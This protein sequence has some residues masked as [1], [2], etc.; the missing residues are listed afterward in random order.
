M[1]RSVFCVRVCVSGG[2]GGRC[3]CREGAGAEAFS[4]CS[5]NSICLQIL[6]FLCIFHFWD[7]YYHF[8]NFVFHFISI[9][10]SLVGGGNTCNLKASS[11]HRMTMEIL[12]VNLFSGTPAGELLSLD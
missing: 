3:G 1:Y 10:A 6:C 9:K 4:L 7:I 11:W 8:Q 12:H 5:M 2:A